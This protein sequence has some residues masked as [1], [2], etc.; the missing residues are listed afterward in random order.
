MRFPVNDCF[1][2]WICW[3]WILLVMEDVLYC[4]MKNDS[5]WLEKL[6]SAVKSCVLFPSSVQWS[7]QTQTPSPCKGRQLHR[8]GEYIKD[9]SIY[10]AH[11]NTQ[12][13]C[14]DGTNIIDLGSQLEAVLLRKGL[15]KSGLSRGTFQRPRAWHYK[16]NQWQKQ[17]LLWMGRNL[18]QDHGPRG[19]LLLTASLVQEKDKWRGGG[20][21]SFN[22]WPTKWKKPTGWEKLV[23][24]SFFWSWHQP[25]QTG[26]RTLHSW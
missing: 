23:M 3:A 13:V 7:S 1:N 25:V 24:W 11:P 16:K 8:N 5:G 14:L 12:S 17:N 10:V 21:K 22:H 4:N 9:N 6:S 2:Y 18:V 26:W 15:L 19:N 20:R